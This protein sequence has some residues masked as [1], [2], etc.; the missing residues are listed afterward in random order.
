IDE[1]GEGSGYENIKTVTQEEVQKGD[2][3]NAVWLFENQ[4][5]DSI[6]EVDESVAKITKEEIPP[7]YVKTTTWLFET[8]PIHEFNETRVEKVEIIGKSIKETLESLYSQ[9]VIEAP[10]III[11]ADE[12]GDVRMA[13]YKL[14]NQTTPEIQKEDVIRADLK[15]IMMNLLSQRDCT[16]KEIFVS[17]EE[18]G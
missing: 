18:K 17:E 6:K 3:K 12:V 15:S 16:K 13:K 2:V 5:L 9:R 10:G 14:M 1:L 4:T 8:T 11:E 7:S